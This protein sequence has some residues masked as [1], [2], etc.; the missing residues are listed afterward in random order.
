M[1]QGN[2]TWDQIETTRHEHHFLAVDVDTTTMTVRAVD[3]NG[4]EIHRFS[5]ESN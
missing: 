1:P 4:A 3:E 5:I 2:E